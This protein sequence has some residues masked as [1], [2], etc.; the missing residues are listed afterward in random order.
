MWF[1]GNGGFA[2]LRIVGV[3]IIHGSVVVIIIAVVVLVFIVVGRY[4]AI[5]SQGG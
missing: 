5:I 4:V 1:G 3:I 2:L